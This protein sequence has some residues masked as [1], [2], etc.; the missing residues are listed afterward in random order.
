LWGA[1]TAKGLADE[2]KVPAKGSTQRP[3]RSG[4][5]GGRRHAG[6]GEGVAPPAVTRHPKTA[7]PAGQTGPSLRGVG[8]PAGQQRS[9]PNRQVPLKPQVFVSVTV[10]RHLGLTQWPAL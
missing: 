4:H 2:L 10:S 8:L 1:E 5:N 3:R 7:K 6:A 9:S